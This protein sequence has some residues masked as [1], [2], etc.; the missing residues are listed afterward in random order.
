V[1]DGVCTGKAV[2]SVGLD[3][4]L[5]EVEERAGLFGLKLAVAAA[6]PFTNHGFRQIPRVLFPS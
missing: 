4:R 2:V 6:A 1:A 5:R 3:E